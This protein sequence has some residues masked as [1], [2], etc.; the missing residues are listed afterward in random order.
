M[1]QCYT[2][3]LNDG[4]CKNTLETKGSLG[5]ETAEREAASV[6]ACVR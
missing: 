6:C 5:S 1:A 3:R 2:L 4:R